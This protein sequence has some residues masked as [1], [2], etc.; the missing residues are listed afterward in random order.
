MQPDEGM[1]MQEAEVQMKNYEEIFSVV[2]LLKGTDIEKTAAQKTCG[3]DSSAGEEEACYSFWKKNTPCENCSSLKALQAKATKIKLEVLNNE[4]YQVISRYMEIDGEPYVMELI[5]R[6]DDDTLIDTS[7][8][9]KLVSKLTGYDEKLYKDALT[10]AYNRLYFE[11]DVK[12]RI[13]TAGVAVID[14]DD[15]KLYN[16]MYGHLTGDMALVAVAEAI[17]KCIQSTDIFIRYGGDEFVLIF[18]DVNEEMLVAKLQEVQRQIHRSSIPGI[19]NMQLSVSIGGVVAKD[20]TMESAMMRADKLMYQA[21]NKKNMVV[22]EAS[23]VDSDGEVSA[24]DRMKKPVQQI[25]IV[26]DSDINREILEEMLSGE[27]RILQASNGKECVNILEEQ[28]ADISLILLDIIMPEMTGFDVLTYMNHRGWIEDIP[29]IMISSEDSESA[30]RRAYELGAV[31]YINRPYHA[32]I[33]YQRVYNTI[34]LYAKQRRL[35]SLITDQVYE[36]EKNSQM[37][38]HILSHIVEFRNGESGSHVLHINKLTERLLEKL[39][40]KTERYELDSMTRSL[41]TTASSLHDIGKIG[42]DEKILN[43]PGKLTKEEFEIMKTHTVIGAE[44]LEQ[45]GI[46]Q[47]EPLVKIA[48]EICRW[49]HERYD[50]RGYP[51]GLCGEEIPISAQVVSVADVYDALVSERVY[52][53]A[54]PHDKALDMILHGECG[55]FNPILLECLQEISEQVWTECYENE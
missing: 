6:L 14:L 51:D 30:I 29:V 18:P 7:G 26:D 36:K 43:K 19:A 46:Y 41:I 20:E 54:I 25:L 1:T 50:G 23:E 9:E 11:E 27:F 8:R 38:I 44:M 33:V 2:R 31:D 40:E 17:R 52:K 3:Q 5:N 39:V 24:V 12:T 22:T 34:K 49:H 15:F 10:G 16:D 53:K 4:V 13:G 32:K 48:H 45:L 35:M 55:Q 21:K 28:G 47:D 42:V 37:L